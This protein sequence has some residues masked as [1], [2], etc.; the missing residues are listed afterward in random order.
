MKFSA[1]YDRFHGMEHP[2]YGLK[3]GGTEI[4]S[5]ERAILTRLECELTCRRE[6][7]YLYMEGTLNPTVEDGKRWLDAFALG[8]ECELSLG[9][10][11]Q[12]EPVFRGFLYEV[13]WSDPLEEGAM[14]LRAMFLDARGRLMTSACADA[15]AARTVSQMVKT[16]LSQSSCKKLASN[17]KISAPP[18]DWDLP[19]RRQNRSDYETVC[20]AAEFLCY[21]FYVCGEELYF[22]A[23][24][25]ER[26]P[27]VTFDTVTGVQK[28]TCSRT[29][30]NQCA[31]V[32]VSGTDDRGERIQ[33]RQPRESDSGFGCGKMAS[34][35]SNDIHQ[36]EEAV[37][38]MAQAK[39]LAQARMEQRQHQSAALTGTCLGVP[40]LRPG[41]FVKVENRSE[42]VCGTFY[43]RSV[44]HILDAD[45]YRTEFEGEE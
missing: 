1:L 24:R 4:R 5:G 3:V 18:K 21:E 16:I 37:R 27:I 30:A 19:V 40:Q 29:L 44:R 17:Q 15:G 25:P 10:E 26:K 42:P 39:Y 36:P 9:Y 35:L 20:E 33:A 2:D 41:R 22:G 6:A 31:A 43:L 38:T 14:E 32:V 45:G 34:V 13:S 23:P 11:A 7:G 28:L 8:A 12:L